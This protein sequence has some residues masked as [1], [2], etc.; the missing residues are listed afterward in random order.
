M[1]ERLD[2][3]SIREDYLPDVWTEENQ[4][5]FAK[6]YDKLLKILNDYGWSFNDIEY[7]VSAVTE[8]QYNNFMKM[9]TDYLDSLIKAIEEE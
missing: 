6:S 1:I 7:Y 4:K 8:G 5:K 3:L 9:P 2:F